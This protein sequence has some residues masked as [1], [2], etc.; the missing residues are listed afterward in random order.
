MKTNL[1][2]KEIP[3]DANDCLTRIKFGRTMYGPQGVNAGITDDPWCSLCL[4][5]SNT[6]V[7]DSFAHYNYSCPHVL[8]IIKEVTQYFL[9]R[10]PTCT[11]YIMGMT[12]S[13]LGQS[14]QK[15]LGLKISSLILNQTVHFI[16]TRRR[17]KQVLDGTSIII[18]IISHLTKLSLISPH[19]KLQGIFSTQPFKHFTLLTDN[20]LYLEPTLLHQDG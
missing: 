15:E 14:I 5:L 9:G 10:T 2:I 3:S 12:C 6:E 8:P 16:T 17:S 18:Q 19:S 4:E 20:L 1:L 13:P 7:E 11:N